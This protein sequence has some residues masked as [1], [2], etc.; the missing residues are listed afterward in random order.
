MQ[1]KIAF[2]MMMILPVMALSDDRD[3]KYGL[4]VYER[5]LCVFKLQDYELTRPVEAGILFGVECLLETY[6]LTFGLDFPDDFKVTLVIFDDRE[7]FN[8]YFRDRFQSEA[9]SDGYFSLG[10]NECVVWKNTDIKQMLNVLFHETQHLLMAHHYPDCPLWLNEGLSQYFQGLNVVGSNK[11]IYI[12]NDCK[13]W[14]VHWLRKGFP[15]EPKEYVNLDYD[16]WFEL[17]EKDATAAYSIGYAMTYYLMRSSQ[18][19]E[20]L[21]NIVLEC[22]KDYDYEEDIVEK[23]GNKYLR[24]KRL[25]RPSTEVLDEYYPGGYDKF[26]ADWKRWLPRMRDYHPVRILRDKL[27]RETTPNQSK[28]YGSSKDKKAPKN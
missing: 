23:N 5:D 24:R 20:I 28:V 2:L 10:D 7:K 16:Q 6:T 14:N 8:E 12:T 3:Q 21:K 1:K 27:S 19:R 11:R 22:R 26:E 17:R 9:L 25:S 4:E 13:E 18:T 15:V